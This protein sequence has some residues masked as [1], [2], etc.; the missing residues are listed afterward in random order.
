LLELPGPCEKAFALDLG[1]GPGDIPVRLMRL[2]PKWRVVAVDASQPMLEFAR[3]LVDRAA[4][5]SSIELV[6][7]DAKRTGLPAIMDNDA[8]A[9]ALAEYMFGEFRGTKNLVY[10]TFSTGMGGGIIA[11]GKLIQG[12][13]DMGGEIGHHTLDV[14][15]PKCA[16]GKTGCFEAYVG[17]RT[18]AERLKE[19]IRAGA[20]STAIV[21]K[22]GGK[23]ENVDTKAFFAAA[24]EGDPFALAEWEE[25]T[26][27]LAQGVANVMMILNPEVIVLG[28]MAVR[29][30]DFVLK[31]LREKVRKYAWPC[32]NVATNPWYLSTWPF[33]GMFHWMLI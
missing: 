12:I 25:F 14:K 16:C 17:G 7:A 10:L 6:H 4:L 24:R 11:N 31:P 1:T 32:T 18:L 29:E 33:R 13:T 19:K 21:A 30:G 22:A 20:I 27:R 5:S 8:N 9:A 2:R 26:E 23:I 28:T 3:R 15:G